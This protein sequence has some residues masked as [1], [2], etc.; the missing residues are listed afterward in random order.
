[1][2]RDPA[3]R[4]RVETNPGPHRHPETGRSLLFKRYADR[5][6]LLM[7]GGDQ[8]EP[9]L[10]WMHYDEV[11]LRNRNRRREWVSH[12]L[13]KKFGLDAGLEQKC[14]YTGVLL[15]LVPFKL[16]DKLSRHVPWECS[17]EHLVC[18][19]NG[20]QGHGDS[21]IVI[22]GRYFNKKVGHAP[23]PLKLYIRQELAKL[24]YDRDRP[25]WDAMG[26]ILDH[27]IAIENRHQL[28]NHYPWQPWAFEPGTRHH[29]MA[30]SFHEEMM[31]LEQEF[32][33]LDD[34]GRADWIDDFRWKW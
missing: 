15:Y 4:A 19:R 21:N 20:G 24:D 2:E 18:E 34:K 26:P 33:S 13:T 32:L 12:T 5:H 22:A 28:G 29:R 10:E 8:H 17:R 14:W 30:A 7:T 16:R 3:Y 9:Q 1:M 23:L 6:L 27:T 25:T 11:A 31:A